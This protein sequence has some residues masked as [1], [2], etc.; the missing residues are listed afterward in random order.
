M[1]V[2]GRVNG[3]LPIHKESAYKDIPK[4]N[5]Q[6]SLELAKVISEKKISL[7]LYLCYHYISIAHILH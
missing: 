1:H 6:I 7:L 3:K 5:Y 2:A 4:T